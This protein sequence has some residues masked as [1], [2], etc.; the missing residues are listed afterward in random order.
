LWRGGGKTFPS[1]MEENFSQKV[2]RKMY[3]GALR[4]ILSELIR[5]NR[6][7]AVSELTVTAPKTQVLLEKLKGLG[8]SDALI[9]TAENDANLAL[10]ARNL[11]HVDVCSVAQVDPVSL[12]RHAK[13]IV[14]ASAIQRFNEM[15]A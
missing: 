14:T 1:T 3:R 9:V 7:V 12:I 10:S 4:A 15:L 8:A 11:A 5:Q 2:N 13:V 6:L